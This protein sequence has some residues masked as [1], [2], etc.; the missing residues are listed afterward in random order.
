MIQ[1]M[2]IFKKRVEKHQIYL[3]AKYHQ[4]VRYS[5]LKAILLCHASGTKRINRALI[6]S[7]NM[8]VTGLFMSV[9]AV[10]T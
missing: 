8:L 1:K 7:R 6:G 3:S 2:S 5:N 10:N 9:L 4:H